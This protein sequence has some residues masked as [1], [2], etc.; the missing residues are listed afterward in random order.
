MFLFSLETKQNYWIK[1]LILI[2]EKRQPHKSEWMRRNDWMPDVASDGHTVRGGWG[3]FLSPAG[4]VDNTEDVQMH[5][6]D[7]THWTVHVC[8]SNEANHWDENVIHTAVSILSDDSSRQ[9]RRL[10]QDAG[11]EWG[12]AFLWHYLNSNSQPMI[13]VVLDTPNI[14]PQ[15]PHKFLLSLEHCIHLHLALLKLASSHLK[16][17]RNI[18]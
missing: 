16:P 8:D 17:L 13:R 14:S 10:W 4:W 7:W 1:I 6:A 12:A 2:V 11:W 15:T 9:A 18:L 3:L 5:G